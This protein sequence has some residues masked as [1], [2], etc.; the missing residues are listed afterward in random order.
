MNRRN[1]FKS[2]FASAGAFACA[3]LLKLL[4]KKNDGISFGPFAPGEVH[5][6]F[7]YAAVHPPPENAFRY[8]K[9]MDEKMQLVTGSCEIG[10]PRRTYVAGRDA[11]L[12]HHF[13]EST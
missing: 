5:Y 3:P 7:T 6:R 12:I 10:A 2:L 13:R 8:I 11:V 9:A 4:P 1:L